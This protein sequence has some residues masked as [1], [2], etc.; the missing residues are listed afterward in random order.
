MIRKLFDRFSETDRKS[1]SAA[2]RKLSNGLFRH[3]FYYFK[4]LGD[5]DIPPCNQVAPG[6]DM[7][8]AILTIVPRNFSDLIVVKL[9]SEECDTCELLESIWMNTTESTCSFLVDTKWRMRVEI[10]KKTNSISTYKYNGC[11]ED[12]LSWHF[13]EGGNYSLVL[14]LT[15]DNVQC[16]SLSLD[17]DPSDSNIPIYVAIGVFVAFA[18]G[19]KLGQRL[20][21]SKWIWRIKLRFMSS[22]R[23][24]GPE[25]GAS[26]PSISEDRESP[27]KRERL[28]SLDTFRGISIVIMIFVNYGG[29]Q[30]WFF[31]H[32]PWN[33]LTVA[34]LVFP[35]FIFIMGTALAYSFQALMRKSVH[36]H[37]I[38]WKIFKR[39]V[40]LF[41]LG[42]MVNTA[43]GVDLNTIRIPGVLQRFSLTYLIVATMH[44][45]NAKPI[46]SNQYQWWS[47]VRDLTDYW[48]EW[49]IMSVFIVTHTLLTFELDA[50]SCKGYLGPGGLANF[51]ENANCTGGAASYIDRQVFGV[52]HIYQ[53]PTCK[54]LYHTSVPH[55]PE[56]LLGTLTSCFLCFLGLQAGKIFV[57]YKFWKPR[58]YRFFMWFCVLGLIGGTLCKFSQNDGWI[59]VNKNLWSLSFVFTLGAMAFLLL[60]FCYLTIDVYKV[61]SGAPFFYPG[62]NAIVLYLGHELLHQCFPISWKIAEHH[63]DNL[64]MDIW[65]AT[66]WVIVAYIL[67]HNQVFISV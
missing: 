61:W 37:V 41:G 28:K 16:E 14:T 47:P 32:S 24:A 29:G 62:M 55:D 52:N 17:N 27:P 36:K 34:D 46:D 58:I 66:F 26:A 25:L 57:T 63:A 30:Y 18:V 10:D 40:I 49:V 50:T 22:S 56:G 1:V 5:A 3:S 42:L 33:G 53:S 65:G 13:E 60:T 2:V 38:F 7:D 15:G 19:W 4:V 64:A 12:Y 48:K 54:E 39:S 44:M 11:G 59:P 51:G 9:Q 8:T 20:L 6:L 43:G 45:F 67:Y 31:N 21:A 35:W 23:L